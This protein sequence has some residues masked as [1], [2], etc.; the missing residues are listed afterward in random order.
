MES[1]I[2]FD[3]LDILSAYAA[4]KG[5][6]GFDLSLIKDFDI[7][8]VRFPGNVVFLTFSRANS[9]SLKDRTPIQ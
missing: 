3:H 1:I 2:G 4:F 7:D 8:D 9:Y 6:I 5:S